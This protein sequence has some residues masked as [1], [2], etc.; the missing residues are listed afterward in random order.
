M[1]EETAV[2]KNTQGQIVR[3]QYAMKIMDKRKLFQLRS[4]EAVKAEMKI[5]ASLIHPYIL[6]LQYAFHDVCNCYLVS[7]YLSG[8]NLRFHLNNPRNVFTERQAQFI[9]ACLILGVEF[10]HNNGVIH[11]DIRPE[12]IIFDAEGYCKL[13]DFCMAR[14][15]QKENACDTSGHAG[16]IAPE[17]LKGEYTNKCDMWSIG[18]ILYILLSGNPP[19][20]GRS[21][22]EIISKVRKGN[23]DFHGAIWQEISNEARDLI[24]KLILKNPNERLTAE[25]AL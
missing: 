22:Q 20:N 15:W 25:Q 18:V 17:V 4:I 24:K 10:L 5:L 2:Y 12:N 23:W 6:Y 13:S 16:Y 3:K 14:V 1:K 21:D 19:F 9:V 8:G 7:E 11:R